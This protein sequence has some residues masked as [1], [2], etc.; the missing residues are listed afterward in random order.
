MVEGGAVRASPC[1][2]GIDVHSCVVPRDFPTYL[3]HK[4]PSQWP[5]MVLFD[6]PMPAGFDG[7]VAAQLIHRNAETF[8]G[9]AARSAP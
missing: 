2:C 3:G 7:A 1:R 4:V 6:A 8:L 9:V 5:S